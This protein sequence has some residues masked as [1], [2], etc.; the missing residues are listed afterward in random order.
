MCSLAYSGERNYKLA[1]EHVCNITYKSATEHGQ[2]TTEAIPAYFGQGLEKQQNGHPHLS[3]SRDTLPLHLWFSSAK[4][5][6]TLACCMK[7]VN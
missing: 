5:Y 3:H 2:E 1:Y 4:S 6:F 7:Q